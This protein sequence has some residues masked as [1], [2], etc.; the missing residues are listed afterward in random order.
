MWLGK[1]LIKPFWQ[2]IKY[3]SG[4]HSYVI[5]DIYQQIVKT[6]NRYKIISI[7]TAFGNKHGFD[8]LYT[9]KELNY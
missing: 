4:K 8:L 3:Q 6:Q 7:I 9:T 1:K 2:H 5:V